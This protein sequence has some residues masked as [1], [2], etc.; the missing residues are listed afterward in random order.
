M[1]RRLCSK[2]VFNRGRIPIPLQ[3]DTA[4]TILRGNFTQWCSKL[5]YLSK[6]EPL[7]FE[8]ASWLLPVEYDAPI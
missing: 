6:M 1:A 4:G 2:V 3:N 5:A 8:I 7:E